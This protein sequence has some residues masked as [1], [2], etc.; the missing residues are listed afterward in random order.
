MKTIS[1]T[2]GEKRQYLTSRR[3]SGLHSLARK[4][5][6]KLLDVSNLVVGT[7]LFVSP[8][9]LGFGAGS[10]TSPRKA[11]ASSERRSLSRRLRH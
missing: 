2:I 3:F 9:V 4:S 1:D 7:F 11:L 8:W 5:E 10:R 6:D